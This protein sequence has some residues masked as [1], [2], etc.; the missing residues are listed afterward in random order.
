MERYSRYLGHFYGE[1]HYL[2]DTAIVNSNGEFFF[3]NKTNYLMVFI[4]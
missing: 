3:D 1:Q 2:K 4:S